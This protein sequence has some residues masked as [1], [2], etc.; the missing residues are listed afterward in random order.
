MRALIQLAASDSSKH[1]VLIHDMYVGLSD[2]VELYISSGNLSGMSSYVA[3]CE[4]AFI[5]EEM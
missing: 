2:C 4:A 5:S 3:C 1:S